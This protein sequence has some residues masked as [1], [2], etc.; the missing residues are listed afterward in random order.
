MTRDDRLAGSLDAVL[1]LLDRQVVDVDGR[2]V[3][4]VDDLEL[5]EFDDG[6]LGVTAL[7]VRRGGTGAAARRRVV[8][9]HPA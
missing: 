2:M 1:H 5:T 8:G 4:K 6:V 9:P 3:C 7:L